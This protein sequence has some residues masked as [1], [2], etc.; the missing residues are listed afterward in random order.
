MPGAGTVTVPV[1]QDARHR[2]RPATVVGL[3]PMA[4]GEMSVAQTAMPVTVRVVPVAVTVD[5]ARVAVIPVGARME[6]V[7]VQVEPVSVPAMSVGVPHVMRPGVRRGLGM[8]H[9]EE[10]HERAEREPR[11]R[12]AA[13]AVSVMESPA[14]LRGTGERDHR[15]ES[16]Y[17][18]S[19]HVSS[20]RD[21][22][23]PAERWSPAM[24][25]RARLTR[26]VTSTA[27]ES[28][29]RRRVRFRNR[30]SRGAAAT[31]A[32]PHLPDR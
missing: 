11:D 32:R 20:A 6:S 30:G 2:N 15:H 10:G 26:I 8:G 19:H 17:G 21:F 7:V 31:L 29:P 23:T 22:P 28:S 25:H 16:E 12:V 1:G 14:R 13:T 24:P 5:G 3:V 4:M 9:R 18:T 27:L